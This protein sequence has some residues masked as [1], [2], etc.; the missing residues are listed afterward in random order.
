MWRQER[1]TIHDLMTV[2][3]VY[4]SSTKC[5]TKRKLEQ[6]SKFPRLKSFLGLVK[7]VWVNFAKAKEDSKRLKQTR[8][9]FLMEI[10]NLLCFLHSLKLHNCILITS[11]F[12]LLGFS[13]IFSDLIYQVFSSFHGNVCL[14]GEICQKMS[15]FIVRRK[16]TSLSYTLPSCRARHKVKLIEL[17]KIT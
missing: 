14:I 13:F 9:K 6:I 5:I 2:I 17:I 12:P 8:V 7:T 3:N 15:T 4:V 11:H 10:L 1:S 16:M